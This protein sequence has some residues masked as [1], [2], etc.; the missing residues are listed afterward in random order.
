VLAD[1]VFVDTSRVK[2]K[3]SD[4]IMLASALVWIAE[5]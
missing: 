4:A 1:P 2:V 5:R 3:F